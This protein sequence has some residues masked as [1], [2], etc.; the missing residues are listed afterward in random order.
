MICLEEI[1]TELPLGIIR[2]PCSH[3]IIIIV[4]SHGFKGVARVQ[5]VTPQ[6]WGVR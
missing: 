2:S 1:S 6:I 5:Y 4:Y 3:F